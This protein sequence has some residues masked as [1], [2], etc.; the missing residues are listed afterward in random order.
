MASFGTFDP[1]GN[2]VRNNAEEVYWAVV[3]EL[4][5]KLTFMLTHS[6][7]VRHTRRG[8]L[9]CDTCTSYPR[10]PCCTQARAHAAARRR[11][12]KRERTEQTKCNE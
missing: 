3:S 4:S 12:E 9:H 6:S 10:S 5:Q 7:G 1:V 2:I 11:D 8:A